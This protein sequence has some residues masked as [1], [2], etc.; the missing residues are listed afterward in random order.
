MTIDI[1]LDYSANLLPASLKWGFQVLN[2]PERELSRLKSC[3]SP[4]RE[5]NLDMGQTIQT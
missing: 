3:G 4:L 2:W 1:V 5:L